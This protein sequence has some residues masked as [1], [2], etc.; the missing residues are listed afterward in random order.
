MGK[1]ITLE[2][3]FEGLLDQIEELTLTKPGKGGLQAVTDLLQGAFPRY[4]WVG[5]YGLEGRMLV[6]RAWMGAGPT[7][8]TKIPVGEGICGLAARTQRTV[9]VPDVTQST[10]YLACFPTTKSEI[11]VP[12]FNSKTVVGEID[13]DSDQTNAFSR[14]DQSFLEKVAILIGPL[15]E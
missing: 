4:S 15:V 14:A 9:I 12:I 5:V 7:E 10:D 1:A 2:E 11:V 6:L 3:R 13:V 8:H